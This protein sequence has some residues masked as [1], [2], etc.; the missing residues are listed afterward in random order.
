MNSMGRGGLKKMS[1][2]TYTGFFRFRLPLAAAILA[3][4]E[5]FFAVDR[6]VSAGFEGDFTLFLTVCAGCLEHLPRLPAE[7]TTALLKRH[8]SSF[9]VSLN[10]RVLKYRTQWRIPLNK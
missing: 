4:C 6:T 1:R 10:N 3:L 9:F 7:S 8:S 2:E 5:A